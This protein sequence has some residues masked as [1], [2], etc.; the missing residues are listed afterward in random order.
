VEQG[1]AANDFS[2]S[3]HHGLSLSRSPRARGGT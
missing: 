2:V 3:D 1:G